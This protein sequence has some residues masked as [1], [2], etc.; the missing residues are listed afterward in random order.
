MTT[1]T[2]TLS[3]TRGQFIC[4]LLVALVDLS[5]RVPMKREVVHHIEKCGYLKLPTSF[6]Q[7]SYDSKTE[8]QWVTELC[9]ARRD[10]IDQGFL[11]RLKYQDAWEIN[12]SGE[13]RV[14][15]FE[16]IFRNGSLDTSTCTFLS[17]AF[18]KRMAVQSP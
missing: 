12:K 14:A 16:E 5:D 3:S 17:P 7:Q 1:N 15:Y 4:V 11:N 9:Q 13:S 10:A 8:P 18:L 2:M 6:S